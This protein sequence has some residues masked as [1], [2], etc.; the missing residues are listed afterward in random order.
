MLISFEGLDGS[1]KETHTK[2]I[3]K[4]LNEEGIKAIRIEFPNYGNKY[5][6][7]V[8]EYLK[9]NFGRDLNP[10]LISAFFGLERFGVYKS[11]MKEYIHKGY[12]ILCDRY[13]H[14]NLIY[15]GSFINDID[16]RDKLFDWILDFEYNVCGLPKESITF[17][18]DLSLHINLDIIK[19]RCD[20]DIYENDYNFL[21]NCHKNARYVS[22]KYNFINIKCDDTKKLLPIEEINNNIYSLILDKLKSGI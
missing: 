9:G 22:N 12:V 6:L 20:R 7:F 14:S 21:I 3:E 11:M 10:Y 13:I 15:Q 16:E 17:F 5:S 18:M 1:G 2:L 4:R 19:S 8:E